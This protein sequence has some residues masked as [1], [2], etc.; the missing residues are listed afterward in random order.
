MK[1]LFLLASCA[2][3]GY[4][5]NAQY[6]C[7]FSLQGFK[8]ISLTTGLDT[9]IVP[10]L[11][12]YEYQANT[13]S[14]MDHRFFCMIKNWGT[15]NNPDTLM[16][17]DI[18]TAGVTRDTISKGTFFFPEYHDEKMYGIG[19]AGLMK[20]DLTTHQMSIV[21]AIIKSNNVEHSS[22]DHSTNEYILMKKGPN[23]SFVH[24]TLLRYNITTSVLQ[25]DSLPST[26]HCF[27]YSEGSGKA[28]TISVQN[29]VKG[30]YKYDYTN[31]TF[32]L[33]GAL[34][35]SGI[36]A[37]VSTVDPVTSTYYIIQVG[38]GAARDTITSYTEG[39]NSVNKL[40]ITKN[41]LSNIE[42]FATLPQTNPVNVAALNPQEVLSLFPNPAQN[43]LNIKTSLKKAAITITD[44]TGK[45]V[46]TGTIFA[47]NNKI[48]LKDLASGSYS[49]T[50]SSGENTYAQTFIKK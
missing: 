43:E 11:M 48:E 50:I 28:Y 36:M 21:D 4:A 5:A 30:V 39:Q 9:L 29:A 2:L 3:I 46:M 14:D 47:G 34:G 42:F 20:Y 22:F 19:P 23:Q 33:G 8:K 13:T 32:T 37:S 18:A 40:D 17:I 44:I 26:N 24:D 45:V 10:G 25:K 41:S 27:N 1:K 38:N 35:S 12:F 49:V 15:N 7:G 16:T 6:L 31:N